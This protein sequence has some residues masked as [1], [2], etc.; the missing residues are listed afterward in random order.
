MHNTDLNVASSPHLEVLLSRMTRCHDRWAPQLS[1]LAVVVFLTFLHTR[2]LPACGSPCGTHWPIPDMP[3][4]TSAVSSDALL[5]QCIFLLFLIL[6]PFFSSASPHSQS[7]SSDT[8]SSRL[9]T[10]PGLFALCPQPSSSH[11]QAHT[12]G[13]VAAASCSHGL[14]ALTFPDSGKH[15]PWG[16]PSVMWRHLRP[17][18]CSKRSYLCLSEISSLGQEVTNFLAK[19]S[20][21]HLPRG[22]KRE[23]ISLTYI[24]GFLTCNWLCPSPV[25]WLKAEVL[26]LVTE[27]HLMWPIQARGLGC[28]R[29]IASP[30]SSRTS[31]GWNPVSYLLSLLLLIFSWGAAKCWLMPKVNFL[32]QLR[33]QH[34][35][36]CWV[37][38]IM[39]GV[40]RGMQTFL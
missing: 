1:V 8:F 39:D 16:L 5:Y 33:I 14:E 15:P 9:A 37:K 22:E 10:S 31:W 3:V 30:G 34:M 28:G 2:A 4:R 24:D 17:I 40:W 32:L 12:A 26:L 27:A 36:E 23:N 6:Y 25:I 7:I 13:P 20:Q 38:Q 35:S 29:C 19:N 11:G 21:E 18:P